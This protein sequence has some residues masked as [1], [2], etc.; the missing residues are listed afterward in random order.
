MHYT[1][2]P[3]ITHTLLRQPGNVSLPSRIH[4]PNTHNFPLYIIHFYII[5]KTLS[6]LI[7]RRQPRLN[8]KQT[9]K[10][11]HRHQPPRSRRLNSPLEFS[12]LPT[13]ARAIQF[14]FRLYPAAS[15][16]SQSGG[17]FTAAAAHNS[18]PP[19]C[20]DGSSRAPLLSRRFLLRKG[21]RKRTVARE[22]VGGA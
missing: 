5:I 6:G 3:L 8:G 16:T 17:P 20:T 4:Y 14:V 18:T 10:H 15:S 13:H 21:R 9:N 19:L 11:N 12:L 2:F 1:Q 7:N 22:V